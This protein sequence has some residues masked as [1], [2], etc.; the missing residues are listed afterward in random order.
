MYLVQVPEELVEPLQVRLCRR[1]VIPEPP[2][3]KET[4]RVPCFP[5]NLRDRDVLRLER[6]ATRVTTHRR[7]SGLKPRHQNAPGR[8]AYCGARVELRVPD[9]LISEPVD[10]RR[11]DLL[12]SVGTQVGVPKVV[13]HDE[14][15]VR[16]AEVGGSAA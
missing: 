16:L 13:C 14:H 10:V 15:D 11:A 5:E 8:R 6:E 9:P 1:P 12:L 7:V 3:T 4:G 2:L